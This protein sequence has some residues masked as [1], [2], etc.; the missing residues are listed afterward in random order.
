LQR[1]GRLATRKFVE[2]IDAHIGDFYLKLFAGKNII[3]TGPDKVH[4]NA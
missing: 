2:L 3:R 4:E 1:I